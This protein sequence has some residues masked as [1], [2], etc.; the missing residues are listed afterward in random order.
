MKKKA[1]ILMLVLILALALTLF[2]ACDKDKTP[3]QTPEGPADATLYT[4]EFSAEGATIPKITATAGT[5]ISAQWPADPQKEGVYFGGW[6]TTEDGAVYQTPSVMPSQNVKLYALWVRHLTVVPRLQNKT[7]NGYDI[8]LDLKEVHNIK[9]SQTT[10]NTNDYYLDI[11]G[12]VDVPLAEKT[13]AVNEKDVTYY[14]DYNRKRSQVTYNFNLR[15]EDHEFG[16]MEGATTYFGLDFTLPENG[17]NSPAGYRFAGWS[18][19]SDGR[20]FFKAGDTLE[21]GSTSSLSN[22]FTLYAIWDK[23]YFDI[24][25]GE[26]YIFTPAREKGVA[27]LVKTE[28]ERWTDGTTARRSFEWKGIYDETSGLFSV[29][30]DAGLDV[31]G[32]IFE[33]GGFYCLRNTTFATTFSALDFAYYPQG[34]TTPSATSKLT[35]VNTFGKATLT[36]DEPITAIGY[37][38]E[39]TQFLYD[40]PAGSYD[41]A[42]WNNV[43]ADDMCFSFVAENEDGISVQYDLYLKLGTI[44]GGQTSIFQPRTSDA[45]YYAARINPNTGVLE[46]DVIILDGYGAA[47]LS[48]DDDVFSG[49]Y[50]GYDGGI[51]Y[52]QF[53]ADEGYITRVIKIDQSSFFGMMSD[54]LPASTF[55]SGNVDLYGNFGNLDSQ[56]QMTEEFFAD[57]FGGGVYTDAQGNSRTG[58]L[59][60]VAGAKANFNNGYEALP[61]AFA[62]EENGGTSYIAVDQLSG[63]FRTLASTPTINYL[64]SSQ[65]DDQEV[66]GAIIEMGGAALWLS[67][68]LTSTGQICF[69]EFVDGTTEVASEQEGYSLFKGEN[70]FYILYRA[71]EALTDQY[72]ANAVVTNQ[73][74]F[75][76]AQFTVLDRQGRNA[77]TVTVNA[78]GSLTFTSATD[79]MD[80]FTDSYQ[81]KYLAFIAET[82]TGKMFVVNGFEDMSLLAVTDVYTVINAVDRQEAELNRAYM[83]IGGAMMWRVDEES[84]ESHF[85]QYLYL[86]QPDGLDFSYLGNYPVLV[87]DDAQQIIR[88][89]AAL[90]Y[91][92]FTD[93]EG[94]ELMLNQFGQADHLSDDGEYFGY[95]YLLDD[96][97]TFMFYG[98]KMVGD[99]PD[100]DDTKTFYFRVTT[101]TRTFTTTTA[102]EEDT[103]Q[104]SPEPMPQPEGAYRFTLTLNG[105]N[106]TLQTT[107]DIVGEASLFTATGDTPTA[108]GNVALTDTTRTIY[109][110]TVAGDSTLGVDA[111]DFI[112]DMD[113]YTATAESDDFKFN[114]SVMIGNL[115]E[116]YM[117]DTPAAA[118]EYG[119]LRA[120]GF[121]EF[122]TFNVSGREIAGAVTLVNGAY[123]F[124]ANDLSIMYIMIAF[125]ANGDGE[126][127]FTDDVLGIP[128]DEMGFI[129]SVRYALNTVDSLLFYLDGFG[130]WYAIDEQGNVDEAPSA[131]YEFLDDPAGRTIIQ[132]Y[133]DVDGS[134]V[135]ATLDGVT[136][137]PATSDD[138]EPLLYK[139][140]IGGLTISGQSHTGATMYVGAEDMA[141]VVA[142]DTAIMLFDGFDEVTFIDEMGQYHG[143]GYYA[144]VGGTEYYIVSATGEAYYVID[145]DSPDSEGVVRARRTVYQLY[146]GAGY[147]GATLYMYSSADTAD[148]FSQNGQPVVVPELY[149]GYAELYLATASGATSAFSGYY[150]LGEDGLLTLY[151]LDDA[152]KVLYE[153]KLYIYFDGKGDIDSIVER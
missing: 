17:F 83:F 52:C 121:G 70:K 89:D 59:S 143:A 133:C 39:Y 75:E 110:F 104:P 90:P 127:S 12:F 36:L 92:S 45:G 114:V 112:V 153:I 21:V 82:E 151:V 41:G 134:L 7:L 123:Y 32:M 54:L 33:D 81:Y 116:R 128:G 131:F 60:L 53:Q 86:Q 106:Y 148:N 47:T 152:D 142:D 105:K 63:A 135:P 100:K 139:L 80:S 147:T 94:N 77:G 64:K 22:N 27:Y 115:Y 88:G 19:T 6:S 20:D 84:G 87:D 14:I 119:R 46:G 5:D 44:A 149:D 146:S 96:D 107:R 50:R 97:S 109:T 111:F 95:Y 48:T 51:A 1:S 74:S 25:H 117:Y 98:E 91:G 68:Y 31:S 35:I 71:D 23:G 124:V 57:G 130:G 78:E 2:A 49:S 85:A 3:A 10:V 73:I 42:C 58:R 102:P 138:F 129:Y 8:D 101:S 126:F 24:A 144:P 141:L 137:T 120:D 26:G 62:F 9:L 30:N 34:S 61:V 16:T 4:I 37:L 99:T 69:T 145:F 108:T 40:I 29:S 132:I 103:P 18:S 136:L 93:S 118:R 28:D 150:V 76:S 13:W 125:D 122:A 140:Y 65:S 55:E 43:F 79:G 72:G 67:Y 15:V 113:D 38:D 56:G 66:E 11:P